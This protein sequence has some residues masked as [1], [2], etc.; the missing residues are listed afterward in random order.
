[1]KSKKV[2]NTVI[3]ETCPALTNENY[4]YHLSGDCN[5]YCKCLLN[6]KK[7]IARIIDDPDD[8]SSQFV[9]RAKCLIDKN[10][11]NDCPVYGMSNETFKLILTDKTQSELQK[12]L[13]LLN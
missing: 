3:G 1:M 10:K 12:K 5:K 8:A 11:L 6:D 4:D 2:K 7:C 13:E 9:S